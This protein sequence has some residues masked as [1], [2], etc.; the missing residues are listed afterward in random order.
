MRTLITACLALASAMAGA[1]Q[2]QGILADSSMAHRQITLLQA[3]GA[4]FMPIDSVR[5]GGDG[6][7]RFPHPFKAT[8]FYQL[9]LNDS[10]VVN[11]VLDAR[12]P[13][14]DLHFSGLPLAD[15]M[16]VAASADNKRLAEMLHVT[17]ETAA[18]QASVKQQKAL[19]TYKDTLQLQALDRIG[20]KAADTQAEFMD[21]LAKDSATSYFARNYA[22]DRAIGRARGKGPMAVAAAMDFSDPDLMR[23]TLYDRAIMAFLQNMHAVEE[24]QFLP[25]SDTLM[26]L[27]GR[28]KATEAFMLE[29]LI[30]LF[31]TYGP[32]LALQHL[33][34]RYV[35][36]G[37]ADSELPP[38][39]R[40]KVA[41]LMK[42]SV[43]RTAPDL[44]LNDGGA[45]TSLSTTVGGQRYTALFFY[46]STC[47]HCHAQM[48]ALKADYERFHAKGFNVVG[49]ALDAD[50]MEFL[51][52]IRENAIPWK[53]YS[54]FKG[55]GAG[56]VKLYQV[57]GTPAFFLL[58]ARMKILAKP[59]DAEELAE[60]LEKL[61]R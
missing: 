37:G 45:Q 51:H 24:G 15:H 4:G 17:R 58:D 10:D 31:A 6:H 46:S 3:Q 52:S 41:D 21:E 22:V 11:I 18:I 49:I 59:R 28:N 48:P 14:V 33:I 43:G 34:D 23:S 29:H 57:K 2:L 35:A 12:E 44:E 55:W 1:Q 27:A 9:A 16:E 36:P 50:S 7:F 26:A 19:L 40:A 30:D 39:L 20:K 61:F 47:E 13:L 60:L 8:G 32:E 53:C 56:A 54:E 42:V 38:A 5:I 25:A